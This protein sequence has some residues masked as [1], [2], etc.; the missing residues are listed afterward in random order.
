[1]PSNK[2]IRHVLVG[3]PLTGKTTRL[4]QAYLNYRAAGF[5]SGQILCLSFYR[6]NRDAIRRALSP[7]V[8]ESLPWVSTLQDFLVKLLA[9]YAQAADLPARPFP[10]GA[11]ARSLLIQQSWSQCDGQLWREFGQ[12]PGAVQEMTRVV[13][14][15]SQNRNG[16]SCTQG[17]FGT[18]ELAQVYMRYIELCRSHQL[19]TF[20]ETSLRCLD[21]LA[22]ETIRRELRSR[23][24]VVLVD[25]LHLA[26]PDQTAVIDALCGAE[27]EMVATAWLGGVETAPELRNVWER[28][29]RW[30][31]VEGLSD[32]VP[33]VNRTIVQLAARAY[34]DPP[35]EISD[36]EP[37][38]LLAPFTV[39]E[40]LRATA[41]AIVRALVADNTL[42]PN[43]IAITTAD[44]KLLPFA[45][46]ILPQYGLPV[47]V[48]QLAV[49]HTPLVLGGI[50]TLRWLDA[51]DE[52]E[53][54]AVERELFSLPYCALDPVDLAALAQAAEKHE[55]SILSLDQ[56]ELPKLGAEAETGATI[57][58]VRETLN[59]LDRSAPERAL[60]LSAIEKLGGIEWAW[61]SE[62]WPRSQRDAW[63]RYFSDWLAAV[64]EME[65]TA[66]QIGIVPENMHDLVEGLADQVADRSEQENGIRLLDPAHLNGQLARLNYVIGLSEKAVPRWPPEFQLVAEHELPALFA[67]ARPVVLPASRDHGVWLEREGRQLALLLT[68]GREHLQ[69]SVSHYGSGGDGQLPTPFFEKLLGD[70]GEID[71]D[72]N[73]KLLH[74]RLWR[75]G[76]VDVDGTTPESVIPRLRVAAGAP[77]RPGTAALILADHTF[78]ASQLRIYLTC[79]L[80]FFYARVLNLDTGE[81]DLFLRGQL[82]HEILCAVLGDGSLLSVNLLTRKRPSWLGDKAKL[83]SR[84][85]AALEAAWSGT[86]CDLPY[87]GR[88][89]PSQEWGTSFGPELQTR[90]VRQ[91]AQELL[92]EWAEFEVEGWKDA[93]SR[94]PVLLE[95]PFTLNL[96]GYRLRGRID[97]VDQ[98]RAGSKVSYEVIDYK[99]GSGGAASLNAQVQKFLPL[100]GEEASD[101]QLPLY[102]LALKSGVMGL[103]VKPRLLIYLNLEKLEKTTRGAFGAAAL[104]TI[105]LSSI[106]NADYK[107]GRVP[108]ALLEGPIRDSILKTLAAMSASPYPAKP[109]YHCKWCDFRVACDRRQDREGGAAE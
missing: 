19:L 89:E 34:G 36:G 21:L 8:G 55:K 39:E 63:A 26:R 97:R 24:P 72:G 31:A 71:R 78:S 108:A 80:Q 104:R 40:E 76:K 98:V 49:R 85:L 38:L 81:P 67:D 82:V 91:W 28:I 11:A 51:G 45:Q 2:A 105:E 90:A 74:P 14:W 43:D 17:E 4:V 53:R 32:P 65:E 59:S 64:Q 13:D 99:T 1:M 107:T 47:P 41:Q 52:D 96:D 94:Q 61:R 35:N 73:L 103:K 23:F 48:P 83:A 86:A 42:T 58:R 33:G 6:W 22:D 84:A 62:D 15:I 92:Q 3:A 101:Y 102:A 54:L 10:L 60:I 77:R 93:G 100:D 87:G 57:K 18:H 44:S 69:V 70:E 29:Q 109:D 79:P 12:R 88:Y 46:R 5:P 20:Q 7:Q 75:E 30:G 16:F 27:T 50:L 9:D 106:P 37:A 25:D 66:G 56:A 68:R 95:V